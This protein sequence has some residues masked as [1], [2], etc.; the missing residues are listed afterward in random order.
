MVG[1]REDAVSGGP[2]DVAEEAVD[3]ALA[4]P[5]REA[6]ALHCGF[7]A[8]WAKNS[9]ISDVVVELWRAGERKRVRVAPFSSRRSMPC[10]AATTCAPASSSIQW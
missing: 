3:R 2:D 5:F 4:V 9:L 10:S 1:E 7:V 8:S 6:A